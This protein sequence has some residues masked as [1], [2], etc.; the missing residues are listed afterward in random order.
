MTMKRLLLGLFFAAAALATVLIV[1][2]LRFAPVEPPPLTPPRFPLVIQSGLASWYGPRY[3]GRPTT[4]GEPFDQ[5]ALTAAHPTLP[6][7]AVVLVRNLKNGREVV[8]RINDRGPFPEVYGPDFY[9]RHQRR[10]I[11]LSYGAA[12]EIA[13]VEDGI[14]PVEIAFVAREEQ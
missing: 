3:H 10:V 2:C 7:G 14:A 8:V 4:S 11:D 13:M 12:R 5:D 6:F 1:A 9:P